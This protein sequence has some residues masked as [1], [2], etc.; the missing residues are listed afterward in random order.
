MGF[1]AALRGL[2]LR[3]LDFALR[4][5]QHQ[6][7][8][9]RH[10]LVTGENRRG[11]QHEVRS[12]ITRDDGA[13]TDGDPL[14][15]SGSDFETLERLEAAAN[16]HH[17]APP[18]GGQQLDGHRIAAR[19]GEISMPAQ[20]TLHDAFIFLRLERAGRI[21]EQPSRPHERRGSLEQAQLPRRGPRKHRGVETPAC[22][23]MPP[24]RARRA[25][26]CIDEHRSEAVLA[27]R[28]RLKIGGEAADRH[29][30][31]PSRLGEPR[32]PLQPRVAG[33]DTRARSLERHRFPTGRGA[34]VV[35]ELTT[36]NGCVTAD[37]RMGRILDNEGS[38]GEPRK[39]SESRE[40]GARSS[41]DAET[42]CEWSL[43]YGHARRAECFLKLRGAPSGRLQRNRRARVV[44]GQE[45]LRFIR[46]IASSPAGDQPVG[47]RGFCSLLRAPRSHHLSQ[48]L[49]DVS[50]AFLTDGLSGEFD[51]R[52]DSRM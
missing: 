25:A 44:P 4:F 17:E 5:R 49:V 38:F 7:E 11:K 26:R 35:N 41:G 42:R 43:L 27:N 37:K 19:P 52:R 13:G 10:D 48:R 34:G 29:S 23:G 50:S 16:A 30:R 9:P 31:A 32:E 47:M 14:P 3:R 33:D 21:D 8:H 2:Q 22:V 28:R 45:A 12:E 15:E 1:G 51:A 46:T 39:I 18:R 36:R 24:H 6:A 40:H 20:K